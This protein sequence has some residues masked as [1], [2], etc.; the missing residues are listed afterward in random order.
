[1][2]H[3]LFRMTCSTV[4]RVKCRTSARSL[5][6]LVESWNTQYG[7]TSDTLWFFRRG[8]PLGSPDDD[9]VDD[10]YYARVMRDA[11]L[12]E[13][14]ACLLPSNEW[15][16]WKVAGHIV[17]TSSGWYDL[18]LDARIQDQIVE[19]INSPCA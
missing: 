2:C 3:T 10:V 16:T 11:N 6:E 18:K 13:Q 15:L 7:V 19:F 17:E 4:Q 8:H 9:D 1:M 5:D 14:L 12:Q